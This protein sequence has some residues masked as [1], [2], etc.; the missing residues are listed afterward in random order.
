M[1]AGLP[2]EDSGG[3]EVEV[4]HVFL[5]ETDIAAKVLAHN[6]LPG[7]E[8]SVIEQLFQVF[9]QVHVLDLGQTGSLL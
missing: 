1:S 4:E 8:E 7:R 2:N 3:V 6:A 9:R 5:F